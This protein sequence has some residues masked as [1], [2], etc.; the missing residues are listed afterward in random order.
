MTKLLEGGAKIQAAADK[1]QISLKGTVLMQ[2][3]NSNGILQ[4]LEDKAPD[5]AFSVREEK[6]AE[7]WH[8]RLEHPSNDVL[9][10]MSE[11]KL[12]EGLPVS[13]SAFR[14]L[15]E[16]LCEPCVVSKQSRLSFSASE[17]ISKKPLELLHMD[18]CGPLPMKSKR[19][20]RHILTITDD[21]SRCSLVQFLLQKN[22]TAK[23]IKEQIQL[24]ETQFEERVKRVRTDRGTE[25]LIAELFE[26]IKSKGIVHE[27]TNPYSSEQNGV[28]ERLNRTLIEKAKAN[29]KDAGLSDD[30]WDEAVS[31]A[32][33]VR[34]RTYSSV[35]E[36]TPLE[37]L[38]GKKHNVSHLRVFGSV[39]YVHMP[40]QKRKK[41]D[42]I[43]E[44]GVFVG[45]EANSEGYRVLRDSDGKIGVFKDVTFSEKKREA[46]DADLILAPTGEA[47]VKKEKD[48]I[49]ERG[50][51]RGL[52]RV[53]SHGSA[54]AGAT[55]T[56]EASTVSTL[57]ITAE[58]ESQSDDVRATG[59][60][61]R[62]EGQ[63]R[64]NPRYTGEEWINP[65]VLETE[66]ANAAQEKGRGMID[67]LPKPSSRSEALQRPDAELWKKAMDKEMKSLLANKTLSMKKTPDGVKPV[68]V[69]WTFKLKR[70]KAGNIKRYKAQFVAK[71][72][73][74]KH[75]VDYEEVFAPVSR[76]ATVRALLALAASLDLEVEQLDVK[77]AFLNGILEEEIWAEQPEGYKTG[78]AEM[79][80]RLHKSLYGLKQASRT[81]FLRLSKGMRA[82]G[83]E[84]S[85]ADPALFYKP[86]AREMVYV[87]VWVNDALLI[88]TPA[89][90]GD[91]KAAITK[92]FN[93]RD[94]GRADFFLGM[95]ITRDRTTKTL[96]LTQKRNIKDLLT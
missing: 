26:N 12:V 24:L 1:M 50:S 89:A 44:K 53:S 33:H 95:E 78:G 79:K 63:R 40:A 22:Q 17:R 77:T 20:Y 76:H 74:Q 51:A 47:P 32:N 82:I 59:Y 75:E 67:L 87:V 3:V 90:V 21:Y 30:L 55:F 54:S 29:L 37:V 34:N 7:I 42:P 71:G 36:K 43:L 93:V 60:N 27:T 9:I 2:A 92:V 66:T 15:K 19:G 56:G 64:S 38:T 18:L 81:W 80:L 45:Y 16:E 96:T 5:V 8:R 73:K 13:A 14:D 83:F 4:I 31:S 91:F 65:D 62:G 61:L 11:G 23:V 84:T 28:A 25:V 72:F 41:L 39:C 85:S 6:G 70:D 48:E 68:P 46:G 88:G 57:N 58:G 69:R 52:S 10:K 35:H 94:L 49:G 86:G